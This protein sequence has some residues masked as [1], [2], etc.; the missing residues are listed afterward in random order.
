MKTLAFVI[1]KS[2][3]GGA[4]TWVKDQTELFKNDFKLILITNE[5]GW[6]SD[7][8]NFEEVF[9]IKDIESK[10][11]PK[12]FIKIAK[13]LKQNKVDTVVSSSA[14]AGLYARL[15]KLLHK[16]H[17]VYVSH[18]WS[19]IY[20]GGKLQKVFIAVENLLSKITD[21]IICV[22][23]RD[24]RNAVEI[25][26][27]NKSKVVTI[28]NGV[29]PKTKKEYPTRS[30]VMKI[31][32]VGRFEHPKR[33][34]L[35]IDAVEQTEGVT[36]DLVGYGSHKDNHQESDK[37][38]FVG[39]IENYNGFHEY[40]A[41]AL[42]SDSEGLPMS[43]IEAKS[44]GLPLILSNVG[45]CPELVNTNGILVE[46]DIEQVTR[47]INVIKTNYEIFAGNALLLSES[48]DLAV[49]KNDYL[50]AYSSGSDTQEQ[51]LTI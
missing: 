3:I 45:G 17:S 18:G 32:F 41:F 35:L 50:T 11:S 5:K 25:I 14:N 46:N 39:A 19:C 6:L 48:V 26:G 31:V 21:R 9:F 16:H 42:I 37:V 28:Q 4:Q 2:E 12:A 49:K 40:D 47:A 15:C 20:N 51:P 34:D 27:V 30:D 23:E 44:A 24:E 38:K 13:I 29:F 36:L 10:F 7:N 1:T 22:S 33:I 43:A 8:G